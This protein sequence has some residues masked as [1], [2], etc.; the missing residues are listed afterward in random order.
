[1]TPTQTMTQIA[2]HAVLE[3]DDAG[4]P[5]Q[6]NTIPWLRR[7][8]TGLGASEGPS[9]LGLSPWSS[10]RDIAIAKRS[11]VITDEQ[12]EAMEFGHL[13]EP[14]ALELFRRRHG[15]PDSTRHAYIGDVQPAPGLLRSRQHPHLLASLDAL[16]IEPDGQAVSGQV[17]N[18]NG[19]KRKD[20]A[21]S[22]GGVP[23]F[24]RV[25]VIQE[26]IVLGTDH[27]WVL[28]IFGGNHMPEPIRVDT[29]PEFLSWYVEFSAEWFARYGVDGTELPEPTLL[30]D[31]SDIWT[32]VMGE[33]VDLTP[34]LLE[35][36]TR[37]KSLKALVKDA[38]VELDELALAIKTFMGDATE[39]WDRTVEPARLA[40]T[41]RPHANPKRT[42][43]LK[44]LLADHPEL[45]DLTDAYTV[46]GATPRPFL[47]K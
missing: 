28:P 27:G 45:T 8:R 32:G 47:A 43:S 25:Q 11:D 20:W 33:S 12:T 17:K 31:L 6:S 42:F 1:M 35:K 7:R 26:N 14:V 13:M 9:I 21:A 38:E 39:A 40:A 24:V 19:W 22:D 16:I 36:L 5:I 30:D 37:Y 4:Q 2:E 10:P 29:D 15:N 44:A 18:V 41:W 23:D 46:D 34:E 3:V